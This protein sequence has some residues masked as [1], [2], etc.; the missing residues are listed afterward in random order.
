MNMPYS[1]QQPL[2]LRAGE[3]VEVRS[4]EEILRTLDT[5]GYLD[6][7]P[8]MPE[9]LRYCG[10]PFKVYKTAHKTC[11]TV[12]ASGGR[13][14]RDCVHLEMLRC[15][16]ADHGGCQAGCLIFWK[17]AWLK[18]KGADSAAAAEPLPVTCTEA[19][20][21]RATQAPASSDNTEI[22]YR[23]QATQLLAATQPLKWWDVRQYV[24]D[25]ASGN[26]TIRH[27]MRILAL[28]AFRRLVQTGHGYRLLVGAYNWLQ[29]RR[30]GQPYPDIPD[31]IP[32]GQR[33]PHEAL[34]LKP[35]EW[36]R[37][38]SL[39]EIRAT[40]SGGGFNR[41]MR[42]DVEMA[43]Y[44]GNTYRVASRVDQ[45]I[46]EKTG[47]MMRMTYPCI[48]LENVFCRAECTPDRL[49]CPRAVQTYWREIWLRRVE[50]KPALDKTGIVADHLDRAA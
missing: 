17:E 15:D 26:H 8:F 35:G 37:I 12:T 36:V 30:G 40:T 11:D 47:K 2:R 32:K 6:G 27:M 29:K 19:V 49:G 39:A 41:G 5:N 28:G 44:C 34:E 16:G 3:W 31:A 21:R 4:R 50:A 24:A 46:N 10:K 33:T 25:V 48:I 1:H 42:F 20:L 38:K 7:L 45:I 18:R 9:M 43:K 14:M 22:A 23:C 13:R